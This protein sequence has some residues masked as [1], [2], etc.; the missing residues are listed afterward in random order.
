MSHNLLIIEDNK[1]H[2]EALLKIIQ[3]LPVKV[4][5][6]CARTK[7]EAYQILMKKRIHLFLLDI[8]LDSKDLGDVSGLQFAEEIRTTSIYKYTPM[9]FITALEDPKCYTYSQLHCYDY[10][11]KPFS[12]ARVKETIQNALEI[13]QYSEDDKTL[14]F[15]K[16]GI[17]YVKR[18]KEIIYIESKK[19]KICM[20]C[21]D[22]VL[23]IPY[24]TTQQILQEIGSD[25]FVQCS[26][27]SIINKNYIEQIDYGNRFIKLKYID[28]PIEVGRIK[29]K[30]ILKELGYE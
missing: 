10:I 26:R 27:T 30:A 8:I 22:D 3:E 21:I 15:R 17:I 19:R 14:Y 29:G 7:E 2:M 6:Y 24:K 11:E 28:F 13:P 25:S 1:A 20:H 23:E 12:V 16:N 5:V 18:L 4:V 9:I